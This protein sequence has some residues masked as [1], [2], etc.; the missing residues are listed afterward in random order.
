VVERLGAIWVK[1]AGAPAAFPRIDVEGWFVVG[2]FRHLA[3]APLELVL[4]NFTEVEHTGP[5]HLLLGYAA[6]RMAEVESETTLEDDRVRVFNVGP[7]R[8]MPGPVHALYG[9]PRDAW[10]VDDWTTWFSPVHTVYDQYWVDPKTRERVSD[11]LRIAVFFNPVTPDTTELFTL[12]Y[13][14]AAPWRRAGLNAVLL[15]IT[16]L[17][18]DVEVRRDTRVLG[19]LAD[20]SAAIEGNRLGRFDKGL[21]AARRRIDRI[22]RGLP[23]GE[24]ARG[25]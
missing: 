3:H 10:F 11:A 1:R 14:N 17:L 6:D 19:Q 22:Y 8:P 21:V 9:V 20:K 5:T 13:S 23:E 2:R 4:D 12:A 24:V 16:R 7:Q 25:P 18:V 15:P